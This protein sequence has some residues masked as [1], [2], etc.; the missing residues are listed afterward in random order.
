MDI[1]ELERILLDQK[2]EIES[3]RG[4]K[5]CYRTEERQIDLNSNLANEIVGDKR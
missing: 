1:R 4:K 5:I 3:L 2:E